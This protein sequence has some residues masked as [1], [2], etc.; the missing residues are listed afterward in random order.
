MNQEI[1]IGRGGRIREI[2]I[3]TYALLILY[4]KQITN[5]NLLYSG[6]NSTQ[7]SVVT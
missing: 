6:G 3:D 4:I 7:C 2:E 5:E 1:K